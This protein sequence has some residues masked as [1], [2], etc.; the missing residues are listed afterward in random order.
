MTSE[1]MM[2]S[3][4][5][6]STAAAVGWRQPL[7]RIIEAASLNA[8]EQGEHTSAALLHG[9]A[10]SRFMT[11]R[12]YIDLAERLERSHRAARLV[13]PDRWD[14]HVTRGGALTDDELFD[15]VRSLAVVID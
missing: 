11:A 12:W 2:P 5:W 14:A 1:A 3:A 8:M 13:D 4:A 9:A 6:R 15:I 7:G 10:T